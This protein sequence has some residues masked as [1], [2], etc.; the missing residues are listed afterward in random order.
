MEK[1]YTALR[2]IGTIYKIV[3]GILGVITLLGAIGLC[4]AGFL[5]GASLEMFTEQLDIPIMG[6]GFAGGVLFGVIGALILILYGGGLA[7]TLFA[8]GE[9]IFLLVALEENTRQTSMLLMDQVRRA[10]AVPPPAPPPAVAAPTVVA[11]TA[12]PPPQ[13]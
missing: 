4:L 1:R 11:P 3:G 5:S 9:A 12:P 7:L 8:G 10:A 13:V 6:T 2:V